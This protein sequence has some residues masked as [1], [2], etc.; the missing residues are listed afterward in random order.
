MG[1]TQIAKIWFPENLST[2]FL[3]FLRHYVIRENKF[4]ASA[5]VDQH[6][7]IYNFWAC[8]NISKQNFVTKLFALSGG[9]FRKFFLK[10][11]WFFLPQL[12][13][14]LN[15]FVFVFFFSTWRFFR[16]YQSKRKKTSNQTNYIFFFSWPE[17]N[18]IKL[19]LPAVKV[20]D[21]ETHPETC[22]KKWTLLFLLICVMLTGE[23]EEKSSLTTIGVKNSPDN[24]LLFLQKF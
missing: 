15:F 8:S 17:G 19:F 11:K 18:N 24:A 3:L 9:V 13:C 21:Q 23:R 5:L 4:L 14:F 10:Y 20:L 12:F 6:L 7:W 2:P 22:Q 16:R 1:C